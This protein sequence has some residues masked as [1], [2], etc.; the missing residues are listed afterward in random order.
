MIGYAK[1]VGAAVCVYA[2]G[3]CLAGVGA[4]TTNNDLLCWTV[5]SSPAQVTTTLTNAYS[6]LTIEV[7]RELA[8]HDNV[9]DGLGGSDWLLGTNYDDFVRLDESGVPLLVS[10]EL[11]SLGDGNDIIDLSSSVLTYGDTQVLGGKGHDL[12][13][14]NQGNDVLRSFSGDDIL[15]GGPG[16]DEIYAEDDNDTIHFGLGYGTDDIDGGH[17]FDE[18]RFAPGITL[19]DLTIT[20]TGTNPF[21]MEYEILVGNAGDTINAIRVERLRFDDGSTHSLLLPGSEGDFNGDGFVG[22][23]DLNI[24]LANWNQNV[25]PD[26]LSY[27]DA[28]G[29]GFVGIDDL[30]IVLANWNNGTPPAAATTVPEPA[31][32]GLL[33]FGTLAGLRRRLAGC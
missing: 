30:N 33:L 14:A 24:V 19:G 13:W 23:D 27:S 28:T 9:I 22:I 31:S 8:V 5:I 4:G 20:P 16:N 15:D 29:E 17:H 2:A 3:A 26:V 6:G 25:S 21:L 1:T 10:V 18:I 7:D 12:I 11:Y 32:L